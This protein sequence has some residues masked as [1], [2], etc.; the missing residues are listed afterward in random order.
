MK[1]FLLFALMCATS[2]TLFFAE[3]SLGPTAG[4]SH[5]G[6]PFETFGDAHA[7]LQQGVDGEQTSIQKARDGN[8]YVARKVQIWSKKQHDQDVSSFE[9]HVK[10]VE[11][12]VLSRAGKA[13]ILAQHNDFTKLTMK[14]VAFIYQ[15]QKG[16][17][18]V[19]PD[20]H[21]AIEQDWLQNFATRKDA[22]AVL[23]RAGE[24]AGRLVQKH[25]TEGIVT[26][27]SR[28]YDNAQN[29]MGVLA[30]V[31][32]GLMDASQ[33]YEHLKQKL[34]T[35][36]DILPPE[37]STD[38]V[39]NLAHVARTGYHATLA[40][41][42]FLAQA[43]LKQPHNFSRIDKLLAFGHLASLIATNIY[44]F[45]S[46]RA[47][48]ISKE[49][50]FMIAFYNQKHPEQK[51]AQQAHDFVRR[52]AQV[53]AGIRVAET[54]GLEAGDKLHGKGASLRYFNVAGISNKLLALVQ[55]YRLNRIYQRVKKRAALFSR[56][57]Q[58]EY[59]EAVKKMK[60][61]QERIR[62]QPMFSPI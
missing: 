32:Y 7:F 36:S 8:R 57:H 59:K 2:H 25:G 46:R 6:D 62:L 37:Q 21:Y 11:D 52:L 23:E 56:A 17:P 26:K 33:E 39:N 15:L 30:R 29:S 14:D 51:E 1:R 28:T 48:S 24:H 34:E 3:T 55:T 53:R 27:L 18:R 19:N 20:L 31:G 9:R 47:Q 50:A 41:A 42:P 40:A 54:A 43:T 61:I 10:A 13:F 22:V 5:K 12:S 44:N 49:E 45:L 60:M 16:L 4:T 38:V 58:K 35:V